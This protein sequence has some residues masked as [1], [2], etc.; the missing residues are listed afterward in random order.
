[1]TGS[2][3]LQICEIST[4]HVRA[5]LTSLQLIRTGQFRLSC[6]MLLVIL[7]MNAS[8]VR[9]LTDTASVHVDCDAQH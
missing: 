4:K 1:M 9:Q 5:S 6:G 2:H 7:N 8:M 3:E